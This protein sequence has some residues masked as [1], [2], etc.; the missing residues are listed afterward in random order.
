[1]NGSR[2]N[3]LLVE[4]HDDTRELLALAL[5][6]M[7]CSV[8]AVTTMVEATRL[9]ASHQF[10]LFVLDNR[11]PDGSGVQLCQH[12]RDSKDLAPIVFCSGQAHADQVH[13]A[14]AAGAQAYLTKPFDLDQ[15]QE[16]ISGLIM[17]SP[18]RPAATP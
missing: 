4:D 16:T 10:D 8:S 2:L 3:I 17:D 18:S 6:E 1:M 12:I 15:F 5:N 7:G 9:I 11:L 14:L 13:E